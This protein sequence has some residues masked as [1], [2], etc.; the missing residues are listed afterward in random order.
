MD[1][2]NNIK[3]LDK[4]FTRVFANKKSKW[5]EFRKFHKFVIDNLSVELCDNLGSMSNICKVHN[6]YSLQF[7]AKDYLWWG[8]QNYKKLNLYSIDKFKK[9][10]YNKITQMVDDLNN[11]DVTMEVAEE[12][13]K[14]LR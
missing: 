6:T 10:V 4:L 13:L 2:D 7:T 3:I 9:D 11:E 14:K 12:L 8:M 1:F 5:N